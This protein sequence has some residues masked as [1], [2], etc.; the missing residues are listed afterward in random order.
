[1]A[2]RDLYF[3]YIKHYFS[4]FQLSNYNS[5]TDNAQKIFTDI[6]L[7]DTYHMS[8]SDLIQE[9]PSEQINSKTRVITPQ[10]CRLHDSSYSSNWKL[11]CSLYNSELGRT[12]QADVN[13]K[14]P[15]MLKSKLCNLHG[16]NDKELLQY[17]EDPKDPRSYFIVGG[18]EK[19]LPLQEKLALN[20]MILVGKKKYKPITIRM[21][22][23]VGPSTSIME[24]SCTK[25]SVIHYKFPSITLKDKKDKI[26]NTF[27][28]F[29]VF[30][31]INKY[32]KGID[33]TKEQIIGKV[34]EKLKYFIPE[35]EY[36]VCIKKLTQTII[37]YR[38]DIDNNEKMVPAEIRE[39]E[40]K[41][42]NYFLE[43]VQKDI[44]PHMDVSLVQNEDDE[45]LTIEKIRK[46]YDMKENLIYEFIAK[47]IRYLAK[48]IKVDDRNTWS[49]KRLETPGR[50]MEQLLRDCWRAMLY[51]LKNN[52][53]NSEGLIFDNFINQFSSITRTFEDSFMSPNWGTS[54]NKKINV[55]QQLYR[56]SVIASF[57]HTL[58]IDVSVSR[59][60]NLEI[61]NVQDSQ[62]GF[63]CPVVTPEG[64]N[65]GI[66][67]LVSILL[68]ISVDR[69]D[70]PIISFLNEYLTLS[71]RKIR[72]YIRCLIN[73]KFIG[74][75]DD[76]KIDAI[77]LK[78]KLVNMRR[79]NNIIDDD[80]CIILENNILLIDSTKS[81]CIR[82]LLI[83]NPPDENE[84]QTISI[85]KF[86]NPTLADLISGECIEKISCLEQE[87]IKLA[88]SREDIERR[89]EKIRNMK[90][91]AQ[92]LR[93]RGEIEK[94]LNLE[95]KISLCL[96]YTHC[97][98]NQEACLSIVALLVPYI[99]NNQAPRNTYQSAMSKQA[100]G[101]PHV[102][103][104][105]RSIDGNVKILT[106]G[107]VPSV[108]TDGHELTGLDEKPSGVNTLMSFQTVPYTEED[109]FQIKSEFLQRGAC[110]TVKYFTYRVKFNNG[111]KPGFSKD[112]KKSYYNHIYDGPKQDIIG[113]PLVGSYIK[114]QE[115]I[116]AKIIDDGKGGFKDTSVK[117]KR[118]EEGIVDK[119]FIQG[120]STGIKSIIVKFRISRIPINGDKFAPRNAQK[121]TAGLILSERF[122]PY[123][124]QEIKV[125]NADGLSF[126]SMD[127][128][129]N[130]HC[131]PARMTLSFLF[132]MI[133]SN[134]VAITGNK[135][136][137][138]PSS[139]DNLFEKKFD[140]YKEVLTRFGYDKNSVVKMN[141][142]LCG[143]KL[144]LHGT[145]DESFGI[146]FFQVLKHMV[147]D[148]IQCRNSGAKRIENG[149]PTKGR[150]NGGGIKFGEMERDNGIT[151]GASEWL[152]ERL[153]KVSDAYEV[154]ICKECGNFAIDNLEKGEYLCPQKQKC[155]NPTFGRVTIPF[156]FKTLSYLLAPVSIKLKF[157]LQELSE[158]GKELLSK[159]TKDI[160]TEQIIEEKEEEDEDEEKEEE[161]EDEDEEKEEE[162]DTDDEDNF[163]G[164]NDV[165][166]DDNED[167]VGGDNDDDI[168]F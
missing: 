128:I 53:S 69:N 34:I 153:L 19:V 55:V 48:F 155:V 38:I 82:P 43:I 42:D 114:E 106:N 166:D 117:M 54:T 109:S 143:K 57:A 152:K 149:Q 134:Y 138:S 51:S 67:K 84:N 59:E 80:V 74:W 11:T 108:Y 28:V 150:P 123:V 116:L 160:N 89:S 98:I 33:E 158:K 79:K 163:E 115:V 124:T 96:P 16:L 44:C 133:A 32:S 52:K 86:K 6:K 27:N 7:N 2:E 21:T 161:G 130:S 94:A 61:R 144:N 97:E 81:R 167:D 147:S 92:V 101:I 45:E 87:Y 41:V 99:V 62:Y 8:F 95:D 122:F 68:G 75:V 22:V 49:I 142:S 105:K 78:N 102:Y 39:S 12:R 132:E 111:E 131:I 90:K 66:L 162:I 125:G 119:V 58:T 24:V 4:E 126:M 40:D 168:E 164:H 104:Q 77:D 50:V 121:G 9:K 13:F 46:L 29:R 30:E 165:S 5:F 64:I 83:V 129:V 112:K 135:V 146:V 118:G 56:D 63:I 18:V 120:T 37:D 151:Y 47:M 20:K 91:E 159:E 100:T 140:S 157:K 110:N 17:G 23:Q 1:M 107:N 137:C 14:I 35:D 156:A 15:V 85:D 10:Y 31:L 65:C 71:P 93:N 88:C 26:A 113:L 154:V 148:K 136:N 141:S 127:F 3:E 139:D 70:A 103:H 73:G 60:K 145:R 25:E 72:K 36:D 76:R